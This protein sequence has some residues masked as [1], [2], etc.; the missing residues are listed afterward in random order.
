MYKL[1]KELI[2]SHD[3]NPAEPLK[4]F[5]EKLS[6]PDAKAWLEAFKKFLRKDNPWDT[7]KNNFTLLSENKRVGFDAMG[8][9]VLGIKSYKILGIDYHDLEK[10]VKNYQLVNS[11]IEKGKNFFPKLWFDATAGDLI[12]KQPNGQE[13]VL[14]NDG[15]P[16]IFYVFTKE[17]DSNKALSILWH[18]KHKCW[19]VVTRRV[20]VSPEGRI[21]QL[22]KKGSRI[23]YPSS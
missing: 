11:L 22:W 9:D 14:K 21:D 3:L 5:M 13:G 1:R 8:E 7:A 18:T 2:M 16:N 10:D 23:F 17:S 15:S 20:F 4:V 19:C 6:G 12:N